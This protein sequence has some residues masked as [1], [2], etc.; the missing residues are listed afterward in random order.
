MNAIIVNPPPIV[1][2]PTER[3]YRPRSTRLAGFGVHAPRDESDSDVDAHH[4]IVRTARKS[5]AAIERA[6]AADAP[7]WSR[8]TPAHPA[9]IRI[10]TIPMWVVTEAAAA[11]RPTIASGTVRTAV[12]PRR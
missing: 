12:L 3:K 10:A 8:N 9:R 4:A 6:R 7:R 2:A 5:S 1:N 11:A